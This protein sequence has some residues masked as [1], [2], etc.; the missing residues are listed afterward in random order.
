MLNEAGRIAKSIEGAR[1]ASAASSLFLVLLLGVGGY[2]AYYGYCRYRLGDSIRDF[3]EAAAGQLHDWLRLR[4]RAVGPE[5]IRQ[6]VE[7]LAP[8]HHLTLEP[9]SL[10]VS[11]EPYTEASAS[12]LPAA[13][14]A[15][16][17]MAGKAFRAG[18]GPALWVVG[19]RAELVGRYGP[20]RRRLTAEHYTWFDSVKR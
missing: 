20:A 13:M 5:D 4:G 2:G 15:G 12:R 10:R 9:G 18:Q 17:G 7:E 19:F 6:F 1:G 8:R 11:V 14:R 16:L 3:D